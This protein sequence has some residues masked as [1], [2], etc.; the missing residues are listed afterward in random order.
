MYR[1]TISVLE[2]LYDKVSPGGFIIVDDY[3]L[4]PCKSA[5][6]DFRAARDIATPIES[7]DWTGAFWRKQ[8]A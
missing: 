7:I 8:A 6:A 5:V 4:P 1:S 3:A 2:A